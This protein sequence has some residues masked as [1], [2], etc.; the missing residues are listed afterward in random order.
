MSGAAAFLVVG[1]LLSAFAA[2]VGTEADPLLVD[3][4]IGGVTFTSGEGGA[5]TVTFA[6]QSVKSPPSFSCGSTVADVGVS[7]GA[8]VGD[9]IAAGVKSLTFK[10]TGDGH[11]PG[12][13]NVILKNKDGRAWCNPNVQVSAEAG[14]ATVNTI[15]FD[16]SAG[17]DR[18]E[19]PSVDKDAMWAADLRNVAVIGIRLSQ[20]GAEAQSYTISDFMLVD[21]DGGT[22][23]PG[24][25]TPLEQA[26]LDAF[27]VTD[28]AALSDAQKLRDLDGDGMP[29]LVELRSEHE[30]GFADSI[31]AAEIV[32][33]ESDGITIKWPCVAGEIYTVLRSTSLF[34]VFTPLAG[35]LQLEATETGYMTHKDTSATGSGPYFYKVFKQKP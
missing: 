13:I 10:V 12:S 34:T 7:G 23:G 25:L 5:I 32:E 30:T 28:I 16:R 6:A 19:R 20:G 27:G 29:D 1:C 9:Y 4:Q 21:Q 14:V 24:T 3:E 33:I 8:F 2:N 15:S 18:N 26:L 35:A 11:L 22:S 31:F 17:W